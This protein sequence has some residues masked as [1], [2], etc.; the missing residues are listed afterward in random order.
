MFLMFARFSF[1]S[2]DLAAEDRNYLGHHVRLARQLPG[3][4]LYLTGKLIDT[5]FGKPDHYRAVLFGYDNP[6][7]AANSVNAAVNAEL[8]ADSAA[9]IM[10]T[11][12]A[13]CDADEI[14][15][16]S[17]RRAGQR[18]C[19]AALM[20]NRAASAGEERFRA[21]EESIRALPGLCGFMSGPARE[22]RG[23]Q[24]DHDWMEVRIV[25]PGVAREASWS[26]LLAVDEAVASTVHIHCL[27]GEV[28]L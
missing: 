13:G 18:C 9:H 1:K 12:V 23:Q 15:S 7:A 19:V 6:A 24:P 22:A 8:M 3:V 25:D 10:G 2:S 27:E 16:F 17:G 11:T 20:Y 4:R 21:Y 14:V 5:G 28:Q 26:R